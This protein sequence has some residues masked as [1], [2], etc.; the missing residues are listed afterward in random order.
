MDQSFII[1]I[2]SPILLTIGGIFTWVIKSKREETL[3]VEEKAREFKIET[4]RKLLEPFIAAFT[5]TLSEEEKNKEVNKLSSLEYRKTVIDLNTFGSDESISIFN[6]IMQT[7]YHDDD[8]YV[9]GKLSDEYTLRLLALIS[10]LLLQIR[11]DLYSKKTRLI[12]SDLIE[13]MLKDIDDYK[14][15]INTYSY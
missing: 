13:F 14:A 6:K 1:A 2:L 11:R 12:R 5:F 15:K 10:E 3:N 8:Y 9:E 4:Y 7:F